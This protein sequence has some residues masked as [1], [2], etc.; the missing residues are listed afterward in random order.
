[1]SSI[2]EQEQTTPSTNASDSADNDRAGF[3]FDPVFLVVF[4]VALVGLCLVCF[5]GYLIVRDF[6][7]GSTTAE[8]ETTA[9]TENNSSSGPL[10]WL[11]GS[12]E[13]TPTAVFTTSLTTNQSVLDIAIAGSEP[14]TLTMDA[15]A[16]LELGAQRFTVRAQT[17]DQE[18][19]NWLVSDDS[20][21]ALW[22]SGTIINYVIGLPATDENLALLENLDPGTRLAFTAQDGQTYEFVMTRRDWSVQPLP[23]ILAQ[24]RPGLT[25]MW[26]GQDGNGATLIVRGEYVLDEEEASRATE[27][28]TAQL[29]EPAQLGNARLTVTGATHVTDQPSIPAGFAFYLVD[30][31]MENV[32]QTPIDTGLWRFVLIDDFGTQYSLNTQVSTLGTNPALAGSVPAGSQVRATAGYQIPAN[33][34]S[35]LLRWIV[36]RVDGP[37]EIE[38]QIPFRSGG[39]DTS[40]QITLQQASLTPDNTGLIVQGQIFNQGD[41]PLTITEANVRLESEGTSYFILSTSPA[42]P[43]TV[44]PGQTT[45]FLLTFQRPNTDTS[46]LTVLNQSFLLSGL[47]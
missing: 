6:S 46:T 40:S 31:T 8:N 18:Q 42:F 5:F 36:S 4:V 19:P 33:L 34:N 38:I 14:L 26:L 11:F 7:S 16:N 22:A 47:R 1:M 17:V 10:S 2:D 15:P 13:A 9:T 35:R 28:V 37:G 27:V 43:W 12:N 44:P 3:R 30:F 32:G 21:P 45:Q 39:D 29:G 20:A 24:N 23:E 25:I 41:Q